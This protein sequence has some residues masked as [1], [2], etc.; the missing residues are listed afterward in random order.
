MSET[1]NLELQTQVLGLT[2]GLN[3]LTRWLI[4]LTIVLVVLGVATLVVQLVNTPAG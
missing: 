2:H 4:L 3:R 1:R